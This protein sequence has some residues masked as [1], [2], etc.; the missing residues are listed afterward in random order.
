MN[1]VLMGLTPRDQAALGMFMGRTLKG[2]TWQTAEAARL[3]E[4]S[5]QDVFVMDLASLGMARHTAQAEAELARLMH[6]RAVVLLVSSHDETWQSAHR[7]APERAGWVWLAKPYGSDSMREALE[8]AART[9]RH[10]AVAR[11]P[12]EPS[13]AEVTPH[14]TLPASA[15]APSST[16]V[17]AAAIT[18]EPDEDTQGMNATELQARLTRQ[19]DPAR[20]VF[21]RHLSQLLMQ[22]QPFE[23]RFTLQNYLVVH[24]QD[25]WVAANT[26]MAVMERVCNSDALASAVTMRTLQASEAED[27]TQRLGMAPVALDTFL[28]QLVQ[29]SLE[30][31]S[32]CSPSPH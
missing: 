5:D 27:L 12:A 2:W 3:A 29:A 19:S 22:D 23:A 14:T 32:T 8:Q 4:V 7:Q 13:F 26:P 24:P 31:A 21:L 15:V 9:V 28:S 17:K 11:K 25:G 18:P 6:Q 10:G 1:V 16:P 30:Q 20:F